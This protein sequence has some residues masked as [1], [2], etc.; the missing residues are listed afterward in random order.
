MIA[1]LLPLVTL[2]FAWAANVR[3]SPI[4]ALVRWFHIV[5]R[6]RYYALGKRVVLV[7][8]YPR[9]ECHQIQ[10]ARHQFEYWTVA[11]EA[12]DVAEI[13]QQKRTPSHFQ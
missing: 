13:D 10:A 4:V 6:S 5:S 3:I 11:G 1:A 12:L 7:G 9:R 8:K 2:P